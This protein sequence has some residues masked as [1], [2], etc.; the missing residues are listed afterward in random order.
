M[1]R[2]ILEIA[3]LNSRRAREENLPPG[4]VGTIVNPRFFQTSK[5]PYGELEGVLRVVAGGA[6]AC[7]SQR[8]ERESTRHIRGEC[9][10]SS[11]CTSVAQTMCGA[12][13]SGVRA[14]AAVRHP[15]CAGRSW[16]TRQIY[17]NSGGAQAKAVHCL[18]MEFLCID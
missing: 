2:D 7:V 10:L 1:E 14:A 11:S 16:S 15:R 13:L 8:V 5:T 4:A 12:S 9:V 17:N 3:H 18:C 6:V